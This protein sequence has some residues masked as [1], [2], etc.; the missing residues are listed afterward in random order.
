ME[1]HGFASLFHQF[2]APRGAM[3]QGRLAAKPRC[4]IRAFLGGQ[5]GNEEVIYEDNLAVFISINQ[6]RAR[7]VVFGWG[8]M[9]IKS[10]SWSS[11]VNWSPATWNSTS[12]QQSPV[13]RLLGCSDPPHVSRARQNLSQFNWIDSIFSKLLK[14]NMQTLGKD[15]QQHL[16]TSQNNQDFM[17]LL[18]QKGLLPAPKLPI[19]GTYPSMFGV[20]TGCF[21]LPTNLFKLVLGCNSLAL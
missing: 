18:E 1:S 3:T 12:R 16:K 19:S 9:G 21:A 15:N 7:R 14:N 8:F 20:K 11:Y 17:K 2:P 5:R 6:R 13:G 10:C 4:Q